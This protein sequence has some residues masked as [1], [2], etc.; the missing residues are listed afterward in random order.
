MKWRDVGWGNGWLGLGLGFG[1]LGEVC[2]G[3]V[4]WVM[5]QDCHSSEN[6]TEISNMVRL[7]LIQELKGQYQKIFT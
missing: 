6:W 1:E 5:S 2:I 4:K 7:Q 3:L